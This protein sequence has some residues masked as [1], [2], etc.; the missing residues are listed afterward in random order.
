MGFTLLELRRERYWLHRHV[1]GKY[2]PIPP[3][4]PPRPTVPPLIINRKTRRTDWEGEGRGGTSATTHATSLLF[5]S[6]FFLF[7][8]TTTTFQIARFLRPFDLNHQ[9]S[10]FDQPPNY[11]DAFFF[12]FFFFFF[13]SS[14]SSSKINFSSLCSIWFDGGS[15]TG[16]LAKKKKK[17]FSSWWRD[18]RYI[19]FFYIYL[20]FKLKLLFGEVGDGSPYIL[21]SKI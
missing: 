5:L 21:Y 3:P 18:F 11:D 10:S 4:T 19:H 2:L 8:G 16:R 1:E 13:S 7:G 9:H 20:M 6:L 14:Y 15:K 12:L 17:F